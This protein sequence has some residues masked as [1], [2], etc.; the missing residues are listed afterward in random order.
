M[1]RLFFFAVFSSL[2]F[3]ANAVEWGIVWQDEFDYSG[4]PDN[5]KWSFD[6]QGNDWDWG[7]NEAQNYTPCENRNAW[8]KMEIWLLRPEKRVGV[9][10][11][12]EKPSNILLRGL[13]LK[14]KE[15]GPMESLR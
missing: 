8:W 5:S 10:G 4:E 6:T 14:T 2:I 13:S 7:N 9:G 12:M 15:I 3:G 1:K 11:V